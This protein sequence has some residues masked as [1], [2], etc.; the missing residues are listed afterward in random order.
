MTRRRIPARQRLRRGTA[1]LAGLLL[2]AAAAGC[3]LKSASAFI[4]EADPG[5]IKPVESLQGV[6]VVVG[7]KNFTEQLILGKMAAIIL[8]VAGAEVVDK[9]NLAGSVASR[10]AQLSGDVDMVWEYTGTAWITYLGHSKPIPSRIP[11]WQAV[12]KEDLR[13]NGLTWLEP[14]PMNNTYAFAT[15]VETQKQ[16]GITKLSELKTLP[17]DE[18]T[19]CVESEFFSRSDGFRPML[20]KYDLALGKDVPR[21]NVTILDTGVVYSVT[22]KGNVC[23]FGEVFTTDGRILALDLA[24]LK[25]DRTFFPLYNVAAVFRQELLRAHPELKQVFESVSREITTET[26]LELNA[27]VDVDGEEPALVARDWLQQKGFVS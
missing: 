10:Q 5:S 12:A 7:S 15:P 9:T 17:T 23:N 11:Q 18:L 2:C 27:R 6:E 13:K 14:A 22:D 8:D 16:L 24:V 21:D 20:E 26:M 4:P 3:G 25:D 19:F 1:L